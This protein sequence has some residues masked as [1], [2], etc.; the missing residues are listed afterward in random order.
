MDNG[1]V[2]FDYRIRNPFG[3]VNHASNRV[4]AINIVIQFLRMVASTSLGRAEQSKEGT[5]D[6][7][8]SAV[9]TWDKAFKANRVLS[10]HT[11]R[12]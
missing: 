4:Y 8:I 9:Q 11:L 6:T 3:P 2:T 5:S 1:C 10:G 12:R 7:F